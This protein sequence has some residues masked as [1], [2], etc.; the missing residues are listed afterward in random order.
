VSEVRNSDEQLAHIRA[1]C[2]AAQAKIGDLPFWLR[3]IR[4]AIRKGKRFA[5]SPLRMGR[6]FTPEYAPA[7]SENFS[8]LGIPVNVRRVNTSD[9]EGAFYFGEYI[10][11]V[12]W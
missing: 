3:R 9:I 6:N 11:E 10:I 12:S 7:L 1:Q 2:A 4:K 8:E 5:T